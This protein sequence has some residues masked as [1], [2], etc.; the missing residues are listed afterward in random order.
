MIQCI[1]KQDG[2][3]YVCVTC[4]RSLSRPWKGNCTTGVAQPSES[5]AKPPRARAEEGLREMATK[6]PDDARPWPKILATLDRCFG[7]CKHMDKRVGHCTRR[8]SGCT[9]RKRWLEFVLFHE[10]EQ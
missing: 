2:D 3:R 8:G 7:G 1:V 10:C 4:G 5:P 9:C 6:V